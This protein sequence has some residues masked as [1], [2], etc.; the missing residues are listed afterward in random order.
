MKTLILNA[1]IRTKEERLSEVRTSSMI[2]AIV[3]G[4]HQEPILLKMD[5]SEFLR[6]FRKSGE[7]HIINLKTGKTTMDVLVHQIQKEPISGDFLHIDFYAVTKGERL[8]TK[9]PLNLIWESLAVK[10]GGVLEE[11]MKEVEVKVL[12]KD[13]VDSFDVD[14]SSLVEIGDSIKLSEVAID[15]SKFEILTADTVIVSVSLPAKLEDF[16]VEVPVVEEEAKE[17]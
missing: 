3:Y 10:E 14:L 11:H 13:L 9:I 1:E 15:S 16:S 7:N 6:T 4:K 8:T 2:P 5:Y 12:P 17:A